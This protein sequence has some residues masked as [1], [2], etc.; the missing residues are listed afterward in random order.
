MSLNLMSYCKLR[1]QCI[2][3]MHP[4]VKPRTTEKKSYTDFS[5]G[6]HFLST[7]SSQIHSTTVWGDQMLTHTLP[8]EK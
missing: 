7:L 5:Y 6:G 1:Q 3:K 4:R 2:L 8:A